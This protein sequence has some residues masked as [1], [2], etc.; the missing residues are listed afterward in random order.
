MNE[1]FIIFY[2]GGMALGISIVTFKLIKDRLDEKH[3]NSI[4]ETD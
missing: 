3:L 1:Y 2:L 4:E